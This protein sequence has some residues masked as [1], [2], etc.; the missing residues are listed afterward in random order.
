MTELNNDERSAVQ[1]AG[2]R[3]RTRLGRPGGLFK[4]AGVCGIFLWHA[5]SF[6]SGM[7]LRLVIE[8]TIATVE[9]VDW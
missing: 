4:M 5:I 2:D 8:K 7:S 3:A 6:K 1:N 9:I